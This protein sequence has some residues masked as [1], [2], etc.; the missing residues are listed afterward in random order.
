MI[1]EKKAAKIVPKSPKKLRKQHDIE[2]FALVKAR[3][4]LA[5]SSRTSPMGKLAQQTF[6]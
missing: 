2:G 1:K 3:S 6:W 5:R 4:P